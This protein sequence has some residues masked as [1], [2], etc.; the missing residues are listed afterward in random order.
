MY[1]KLINVIK[2]NKDKRILIVSHATALMTLFTK[3]CD[4][5]LDSVYKF[6]D[7]VFFEGNWGF[8]ESFKLEFNDELELIS[9]KNIKR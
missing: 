6:N 4:I 1:D 5:D 2:D 3:W 9:I 7:K 8:C